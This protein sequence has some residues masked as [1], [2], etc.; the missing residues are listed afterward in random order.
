MKRIWNDDARA[1]A[2]VGG[3]KGRPPW[4]AFDIAAFGEAKKLE[5]TREGSMKNRI[6][7]LD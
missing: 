4:K 5:E 2:D 3:G 1:W 7:A 6:R